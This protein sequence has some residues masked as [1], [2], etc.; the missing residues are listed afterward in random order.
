MLKAELKT[1]EITNNPQSTDEILNSIKTSI[2]KNKFKNMT[3]DISSLNIFD[4]SKII[5][6]ASTYHFLKFAQGSIN[7]IVK[8]KEVEKML[9]PLNLGNIKFIS[10]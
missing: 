3:I 1:N 2:R 9:K 4:A 5:S 10:N 7:W 8:S 6:M